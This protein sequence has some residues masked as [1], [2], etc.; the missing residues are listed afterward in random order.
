MLTSKAFLLAQ[1][2]SI[3]VFA[4]GKSFELLPSLRRPLSESIGIAHLLNKTDEHRCFSPNEVVYPQQSRVHASFH[5][6]D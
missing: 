2:S 6:V 3:V 1:K 5:L 4:T